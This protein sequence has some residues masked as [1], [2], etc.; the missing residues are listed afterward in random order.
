MAGSENA[1]GE[2]NF[3]KSVRA[4]VAGLKKFRKESP[5][6]RYLD[7]KEILAL[8]GASLGV[9]FITNIA[10]MYVTVGQ[11][12]SVRRSITVSQQNFSF[13]DTVLPNGQ[14]KIIPLNYTALARCLA[15][16]NS[17]KQ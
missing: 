13:T 8:G 5:K 16:R 17:T 10:N 1:K 4:L 11:L 9:S 2:R 3:K 15:E 6:G 14:N 12:P 7:L